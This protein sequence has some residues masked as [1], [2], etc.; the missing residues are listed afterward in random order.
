M[1][2]EQM[3]K[4]VLKLIEEYDESQETHF[5]ED[6]DIQNKLN[7][8]INQ[9][10]YELARIKKIPRYLEVEVTENQLLTFKDLKKVTENEVYQVDIIKGTEYEFKAS[11]T[12]VKFLKKGTAEIELFVYPKRIDENTDNDYEFE[13]SDDVLEIM[14]YGVAGDLLKSDISNGYGNIYTQ[15]YEN[16]KQLI[17]T[18]YSSGSIEF[19]GGIDI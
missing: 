4:K 11:G 13:L 12:I 9:I 14:P 16:L 3:K 1:T 8:V 18:R 17:D 7:D 10:Q 19:V 2:L 15:K 5:T 6:E